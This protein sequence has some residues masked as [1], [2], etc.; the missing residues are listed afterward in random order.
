MT[1]KNSETSPSPAFRRLGSG[2]APRPGLVQALRFLLSNL[3]CKMLT[4]R[5]Y[6]CLKGKTVPLGLGLT[7][8]A[9]GLKVRC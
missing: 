1:G 3:L 7:F 4:G 9:T 8:R 5:R 2:L 6:R